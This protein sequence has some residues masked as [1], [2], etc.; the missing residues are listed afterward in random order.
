MEFLCSSRANPGYCVIPQ[1][2]RHQLPCSHS[3]NLCLPYNGHYPPIAIGPSVFVGW[4]R[5][6]Q[7]PQCGSLL[8]DRVA[9]GTFYGA[10]FGVLIVGIGRKEGT[11]KGRPSNT[12]DDEWTKLCGGEW[13]SEWWA[14][15]EVLRINAGRGGGSIGL[16]EGIFRLSLGWQLKGGQGR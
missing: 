11:A 2:L 3:F 9:L 13:G 5:L 1:L 12:G 10:Q 14:L 4:R 7:L 16:E 6:G 8:I 15:I